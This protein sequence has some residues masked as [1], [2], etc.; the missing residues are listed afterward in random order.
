MRE[1]FQ[2]CFAVGADGAFFPEKTAMRSG[3]AGSINDR[4]GEF[5]DFVVM[6]KEFNRMSAV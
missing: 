1:A 6:L 5:C 4:R 2:D 3:L